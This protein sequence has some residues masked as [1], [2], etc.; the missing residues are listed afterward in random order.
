ML[1]SRLIR[2]ALEKRHNN[3]IP[4]HSASPCN[5]IVKWKLQ[6]GQELG[7]LRLIFNT[8]WISIMCD[9][10]CVMKLQLVQTF[11]DYSIRSS[12]S[13]W[14]LSVDVCTVLED[15][16][17]VSCHLLKWQK[18]H[19]QSYL[20]DTLLLAGRVNYWHG[21]IVIQTETN[22]HSNKFCFLHPFTPPKKSE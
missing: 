21:I 15:A 16:C 1:S 10:H 19:F 4:I 2:K 18:W 11:K 8:D 5:H 14:W 3:N 13:A 22:Y 7:H 17:V 20:H 12:M 6:F 9:R